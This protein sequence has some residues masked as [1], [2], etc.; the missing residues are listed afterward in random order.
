MPYRGRIFLPIFFKL[1]T[2]VSFFIYWEA[3]ILPLF[4]WDGGGE[5]IFPKNC[6]F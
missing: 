5:A 3:N 1:G 2:T 4:G 6:G